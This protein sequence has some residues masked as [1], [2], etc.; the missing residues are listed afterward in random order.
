MLLR[1]VMLLLFVLGPP[2]PAGS[3]RNSRKYFDVEIQDDEYDD[4]LDDSDV[5]GQSP[6]LAYD[7]QLRLVGGT[8]NPNLIPHSSA[9]GK[10]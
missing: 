10:H 9:A 1:V 8:C 5:L 7:Q 3:E 4:G 6:W 2:A